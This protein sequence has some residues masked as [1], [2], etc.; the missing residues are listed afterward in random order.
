[1]NRAYPA[2]T[3]QVQP[4]AIL[5]DGDNPA[6]RPIISGLT[7][8][9]ETIYILHDYNSQYFT[10]LKEAVNAAYDSTVAHRV[11]FKRDC[12]GRNAADRTIRVILDWVIDNSHKEYLSGI[13]K[14]IVA[15]NNRYGFD[16]TA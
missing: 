4:E 15:I 1:M 3:S 6:T 5:K 10:S 2:T 16:H 7:L 8:G 12:T 11:G 14:D 9:G 13:S